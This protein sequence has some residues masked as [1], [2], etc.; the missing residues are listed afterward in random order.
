[1]TSNITKTTQSS[2]NRRL[3]YNA[4]LLMAAIT[5]TFISMQGVQAASAVTVTLDKGFGCGPKNWGIKN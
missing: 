4:L 5:V 2:K 3:Q 1:M